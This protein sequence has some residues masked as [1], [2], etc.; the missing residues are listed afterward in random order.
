[1]GIDL[2]IVHKITSLED[3]KNLVQ[4]LD[5]TATFQAKIQLEA[6]IRRLAKRRDKL[7]VEITV[8]EMERD[9]LQPHTEEKP[10]TLKEVPMGEDEERPRST[11]AADSR[12]LI[13]E[14]TE[15]PAEEQEVPQDVESNTDL[16]E[17]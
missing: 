3:L 4:A 13:E 7:S 12:R 8:L 17:A 1:M 5:Q 15:E 16:P 9:E 2:S 6:E 10:A 11:L 14:I